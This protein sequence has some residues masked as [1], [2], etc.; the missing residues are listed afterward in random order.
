MVQF[1]MVFGRFC[2]ELGETIRDFDG[3]CER[4]EVGD[5][6]VRLDRGSSYSGGSTYITNNYSTTTCVT[7]RK[8][9]K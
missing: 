8:K 9:V 5:G 6:F 2:R 4:S 7:S 3:F 1:F